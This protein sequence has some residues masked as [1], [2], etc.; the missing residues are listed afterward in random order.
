MAREGLKTFPC[1]LDRSG[2][3]AVP[4][5]PQF[6]EP[7]VGGTNP[8]NFVRTRPNLSLVSGCGVQLPAGVSTHALTTTWHT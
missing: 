1:F 2:I 5:V 8:A 7:T 4:A 3:A 6:A